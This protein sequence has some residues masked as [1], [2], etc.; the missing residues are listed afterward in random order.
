MLLFLDIVFINRD[1]C[2]YYYCDFMWI[3]IN[4]DFDI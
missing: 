4:F 2:D 1:V 3:A